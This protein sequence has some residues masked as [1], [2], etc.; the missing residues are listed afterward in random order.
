MSYKQLLRKLI[1]NSLVT[2]KKCI[3]LTHWY[4][5]EYKL[6][7]ICEFHYGS[8][9]HTTKYFI[10][11][12]FKVK[13]PI[14]KKV[15]TFKNNGSEMDI[16]ISKL[17]EEHNT[18]VFTFYKERNQ[19]ETHIVNVSE[20]NWVTQNNPMFVVGEAKKVVV[21]SSSEGKNPKFDKGQSFV[22]YP[23]VMVAT[24]TP[25]KLPYRQNLF[26]ASQGYGN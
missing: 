22:E 25:P 16:L 5:P 4:T 1:Q 17:R 24:P 10:V 23:H 21:E 15:L 8:P 11:F 12:K 18:L 19:W 14:D 13:E 2:S 20:T 26:A 3:P 7:I 9:R 6:N